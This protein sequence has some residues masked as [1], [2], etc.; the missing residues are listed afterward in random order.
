M[1]II[2]P[3][4]ARRSTAD[5]SL[6]WKTLI[7][8]ETSN[9]LQTLSTPWWTF[10]NLDDA[11]VRN[12]EPKLGRCRSRTSHQHWASLRGSP[13][14]AGTRWLQNC[15]LQMN[16]AS[17]QV[18]AVSSQSANSSCSVED[19]VEVHLCLLHH[20]SIAV[21][22]CRCSAWSV[23]TSWRCRHLRQPCTASPAQTQHPSC[24]RCYLLHMT[25]IAIWTEIKDHI[26]YPFCC[27][28]PYHARATTRGW[29]PSSWANPRLAL[30]KPVPLLATRRSW[31]AS[32]FLKLVKGTMITY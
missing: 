9:A 23:T 8:R 12:S 25:C 3:L 4:T 14:L 30:T 2:V 7:A 20:P 21:I 16:S 24:R 15:K 32:K 17:I 10:T 1:I 31:G 19:S 13:Q 18:T 11:F 27:D 5:R 6:C 28:H 22:S 29:A 26:C